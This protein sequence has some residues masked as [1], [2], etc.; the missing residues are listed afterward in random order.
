MIPPFLQI[1]ELMPSE[2]LK[3]LG[4]FDICALLSVNK[5]TSSC[6]LFHQLI[7]DQLS[8]P[9]TP[10]SD[11]FVE[12]IKHSIKNLNFH[13][14]HCGTV[15]DSVYGCFLYSDKCFSCPKNQFIHGRASSIEGENL[16]FET[17]SSGYYLEDFGGIE[18]NEVAVSGDDIISPFGLSLGNGFYFHSSKTGEL[19][20]YGQLVELAQEMHDERRFFHIYSSKFLTNDEFSFEI[21]CKRRLLYLMLREWWMESDVQL[22]SVEEMKIDQITPQWSKYVPHTLQ[23]TYL[24]VRNIFF[25]DLTSPTNVNSDILSADDEDFDESESYV[26]DDALSLEEEAG[27]D[28]DDDEEV[29]DEHENENVNDD[30]LM[31]RQLFLLDFNFLPVNVMNH[32]RPEDEGNEENE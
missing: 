15:L 5:W 11:T 7:S 21:G 20:K 25:N 3:F 31:R 30:E 2:I 1:L 4:P 23:K 10:E 16:S 6:T 27:Y 26:T 32:W 18:F 13:C 9:Y 22:T 29:N 17:D 28:E 19:L 12:D 8:S 24:V 14:T